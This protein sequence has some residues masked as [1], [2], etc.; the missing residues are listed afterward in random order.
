VHEVKLGAL[1]RADNG[2]LGWQT[3]ALCRMLEPSKVMII[4]SRP[5]N[6]AAVKQHPERFADYWSMI[7]DGF[8][9][10]EQCH[11][12]LDGLTHVLTCE[13]AYNMELIAEANRRGVR[14]YIQHNVEFLDHL[15]KPELPL[16]TMFLSPSAWHLDMMEAK[17]PGR[18]KLL[19]PP[20]FPQ[21]F[22]RARAANLGRKGKRRF[23]FVL[24]K[25]AHGD[26]NGVMLVMHAMQRSRGDYELVVKSQERV[27][28]LLRDRR[29]VWDH[30]APE[31][32]QTLYEGF[33]A[34][35]MPRRYGGLC[36]PMN[37]ALTSGLP[38]IMSDT[39]PNNAVLPGDWL[40]PGEFKGWPQFY[41][42]NTASYCG[43]TT[44]GSHCRDSSSARAFC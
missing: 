37:E 44:S 40:V 34:L 15:D 20:I 43:F 18:V 12:F 11:R 42:L 17:F 39:S 21:H 22:T 24:G 38:V 9:T 2:G 16:P 19:P 32:Q 33:D 31:D 41:R 5:F 36:L 30:T 25:P 13:T 29:I 26:R 4:D 28:P 35:I 14:S 10:D 27:Q 1:V 7:T 8:P 23:L 3:A 6:G